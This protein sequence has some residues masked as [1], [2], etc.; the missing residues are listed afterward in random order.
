[1]AGEVKPNISVI[2]LTYGN[3]HRLEE[4]IECFLRQDYDGPKEMVVLN[5]APQQTLIGV[6][7]AVR[8]HNLPT[9]PPSIGA[10]RNLAITLA[11]G[12]I[13][14]TLDSD[15]QILP[16]HL[17]RYAEA[18]EKNPKASWVRLSPTYY[19][20][21]WKIKNVFGGWCNSI[22]FKKAVWEELQG[23]SPTMSVG[24]DRQF[25]S[26][27][28]EKFEGVTVDLPKDKITAIYN[29]DTGTYHISG[30]GDDKAGLTPAY[31]RSRQ[32]FESKIRR[33]VEPTGGILIKP[34]AEHDPVMMRREFTTRT[35]ANIPDNAVALVYIGRFG[36]IVNVLPIAQH[37]H[38]T[39]AT[40][41]LVVGNEFA[42]LLDSV[43]YLKAYPVNLRHDQ[44]HEGMAIA[45]KTFKHVIQCQ[46][47][48][49]NY[50]QER[51]TEAYNKES[52]RMTGFVTEF[53]NAVWRPLFDLRDRDG[54]SKLVKKFNPAN[55]PMI[56]VNVSKGFSSPFDKGLPLLQSIERT[57]G[58][59]Y[60]IVNMAEVRLPHVYDMLGLI[61]AAKAVVTIDTL[62]LHF[63]AAC[64]TPT[65][66]LVNPNPWVGS[67][68][69]FKHCLK[70]SYKDVGVGFGQF[71]KL[72]KQTLEMPKPVVPPIMALTK[73]PQRRVFHAVA[74]YPEVME[75][76]KRR[77]KFASDSWERLYQNGVV[78]CDLPA[79]WGRSQQ[80][81]HAVT[82]LPYIRD[83]IEPAIAQ[84]ND[85][86]IILYTNNDI[87]LH[88]D[89][90]NMLR[91]YCGIWGCV[92]IQRCELAGA[93]PALALSP[94][95]WASRAKNEA[96]RHVGRDCFAF[97]KRWIME[98]W[99]EVP[100][101]VVGTTDW[102][103]C[104]VIMMRQNIG[105][106]STAQS[107]HRLIWPAEMPLGWT[108]HIKHPSDWESP[109]NIEES[110]PNLYNRKLF[111]AWCEKHEPTLVFDDQ[112]HLVK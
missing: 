20:E 104:M 58:G 45:K 110:P 60:L 41:Y 35:H 8:I 25:V 97:T 1:M 55:R 49:Q 42:P 24:E 14:A 56:L 64:E 82:Q 57:W 108:A 72:L 83:I 33:H 93:P 79:P 34:H 36:D 65:L 28:S 21:H 7:P 70:L 51:L 9:R 2:T 66:A 99:D 18:F 4:A 15:D 38:N 5:T 91:F 75:R 10:C 105:F 96:F 80:H 48:G 39:Y 47:F 111:R 109:K 23:Y 103:N 52:W 89:L 94:V 98:R 3:V 101:F 73:P 50:T 77:K 32:D 31:D 53:N 71:H 95:E 87:I 22:A 19:A 6:F 63:C 92:A 81:L 78:K 11:N 27:L 61:D 69:R 54:E 16:E 84:A 68:P 62:L 67:E 12:D 29:W 76:E 59:D 46:I 26:R 88:P 43:S 13:I 107:L 37:I 85:D 112:N 30:L 86:D 90:P 106:T 102:D 44:L 100:D 17:S 74:T 40:P